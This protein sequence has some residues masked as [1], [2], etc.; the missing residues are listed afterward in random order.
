MPDTQPVSV[1][2]KTVDAFRLSRHHLSTRQ[3]LLAMTSVPGDIGGAQAQVLSAAQLSIWAR[4]KDATLQQLESAIWKDHLLVKSWCMRGTLFLLP[5]DQLAVFA[6]GSNRRPAYHL[7]QAATR[8]GSTEALDK[9]LDAVLEVLRQPSTRSDLAQSLSKTYGY[10]LKSK[11]GGGWGN[12]TAVPWVVVGKESL[13]VGYLLH[14]IGARQVICSGPSNGNESTYVRA[15]KW[16]S[17]WRDMPVEEAEKKLLEKYLRAFGPSTVTDFALWL[18]VYVRDAKEIWSRVAE[19]LVQVDVEGWR[20]SILKADLRKLE[21]AEAEGTIV[22][23]LPNFDSFLLG[24]KSH[25]NLVDEKN[26]RKVYRPQGWVS[27]VLLVNGRARGVWSQ[28]RKGRSLG[29]RV[30]PFSK[31]S[32]GIT[33]DLKTEAS[34]LGRFLE[35]STVKTVIG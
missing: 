9:L 33:S 20:A 26:Y 30:T 32:P 14:L 12:K 11:A 21:N 18:G 1:S 31:L 23:L 8:L 10:K 4:V 15:D 34:E 35:C 7:K 19:D 16:V 5:S 27:P 25:R 3:S 24:H 13:P 29:V 2:W 17:Q 28:E 6:R 22:R